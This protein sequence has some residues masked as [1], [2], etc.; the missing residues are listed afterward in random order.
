MTVETVD[1]L[2]VEQ[3]ARILRAAIKDKTYLDLPLGQD[4]KAYLRVKRKRL[5]RESEIAWENTLHKLVQEFPDLRVE[6]F[7]PPRGTELI[8]QFMDDAWGHLSPGY[9]NRQLTI[10]NDFFRFYRRRERLRGDPMLAIEKARTETPYRSA[11][12]K[13]QVQAIVASQGALRDQIACRLM[14]HYGLRQGSM[15]KIQFKHFDTSRRQLTVFS[16]GS[17][18][19][20]MGIPE[21]ALWTDLQMH[22]IE[23]YDSPSAPPDDYLLHSARGNRFHRVELYEKPMSNWTFHTWW[24][25]RLEEA[26]VVAKGTTSG[27]RPHKARH[28]AG[29]I[30][31]DETHNL[32]AAQMLLG[33]ANI[34]TTGNIYTSWND[35]QLVQT[36]A[37]IWGKEDG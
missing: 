15:R 20:P 9:F 11:Y 35:E 30:V 6:D 31:L 12:S 7:E 29:Q 27:E 18:V 36:M 17:K 16:K 32:K 37:D 21:P 22:I 8:E 24:Y 23:T 2:T 26:G 5:T 13:D 25:K 3:A 14:L 28:T 34:A 4:V 19:R 33:H 10:I 1:V